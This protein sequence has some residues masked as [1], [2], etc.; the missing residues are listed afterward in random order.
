[1]SSKRY[2]EHGSR[3]SIMSCQLNFPSVSV[4]I[5][6]D[7]LAPF[8]DSYLTSIRRPK[9]SMWHLIFKFSKIMALSFERSLSPLGTRDTEHNDR[10]MERKKKIPK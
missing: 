5:T 6:V 3:E 7:R 1:M 10:G 2:H 8:N 9:R 4:S